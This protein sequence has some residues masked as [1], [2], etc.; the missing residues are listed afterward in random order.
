VKV[1]PAE[2]PGRRR[3]ED[4]L[5]AIEKS[6]DGKTVTGNVIEWTIEPVVPV[7]VRL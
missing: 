7:M 1:D 6:G 5:A 3:T 4:G 2:E